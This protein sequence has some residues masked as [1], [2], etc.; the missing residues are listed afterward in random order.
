MYKEETVPKNRWFR[1]GGL[2]IL[3][4]IPLLLGGCSF[5][6]VQSALDPQGPIAR[7]QISLLTYTAWLSSFVILGVGGAL[8]WA[9]VRY[10]AKPGDDSIPAQ[11]HG[12]TLVEISLIVLAAI[13]TVIVVV[14]AVRTIFRT[15]YRVTPTA[16]DV[17]INVMGYQ[18]WWAFDYPDLGI[19]TANE[20][21]IPKGKRVVFKL[22]SADVLHSFW[23]PKLAGKRDLIPNQDNQL[24]FVTDESTPEG[25][26]YGQCSELCLGAH[27]YMRFRVIVDSEEN[28]AKW[29]DKFQSIAP[30]QAST[31]ALVQQVQTDPLVEQGKA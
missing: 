11:S 17:V 3:I 29:V 21:H 1:L 10:R 16:D 2:G 12:N 31:S 20:I 5:I 15:E 4:L 7:Q 18:W 6:Q 14:P 30:L 27:A 28:F 22:N 25:V 9:I 26:Y 19:T 8:F 13:I 24:W 23:V